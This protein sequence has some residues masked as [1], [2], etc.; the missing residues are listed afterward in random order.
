MVG[1][2]LISLR[3]PHATLWMHCVAALAWYNQVRR[4][5]C[6]CC[7]NSNSP[8][9]AGVNDSTTTTGLRFFLGKPLIA[10]QL[11]AGTTQRK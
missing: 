9:P 4:P 1:E 10:E 8:L 3:Y 2:A 6:G 11:L 7:F 5:V